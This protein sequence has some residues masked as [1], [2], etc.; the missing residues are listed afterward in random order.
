MN[1]ELHLE[2]MFTGYGKCDKD[3][4]RKANAG[5]PHDGALNLLCEQKMDYIE[6]PISCSQ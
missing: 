4:D 2:S 5:N 3:V 6:N 1:G